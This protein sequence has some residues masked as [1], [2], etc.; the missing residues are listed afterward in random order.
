MIVLILLSLIYWSVT[1]IAVLIC[2]TKVKHLSDTILENESALPMVSIVIPVRDEVETFEAAFKTMLA[3]DYPKVEF[4]IIDDRSN[5]GSSELIDRIAKNDDRIRVGHIK[6]LPDTWLGKVHALKTGAELAKGDFILFTDADIHFS[7]KIL[8]KTISKCIDEKIDFITL[9]PKFENV[10]IILDS[11]ISF[12][13]RAIFSGN[14][15]WETN[16]TKSKHAVGFGPFML[17]R[18]TK[19]EH[20]RGFEW[21]KMDVC[22]DLAFGLL[23]KQA[24]ARCQV[25]VAPEDV[26]LTYARSIKDYKSSIE[27]TGF[28]YMGHF[29][30]LKAVFLPIL[31]IVLE[32]VPFIGLFFWHWPFFFIPSIIS[33]LIMFSALVLFHRWAKRPLLSCLLSLIG[34]IVNA[35]FI[36]RST[37]LAIR[38]KG[39]YWRG[40]FYSLADLRR[41]QR[42]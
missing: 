12:M 25:L 27:K 14:R 24:D 6:E 35:V 39:I 21:I 16:D 28:A 41:E 7:T 17:V 31:A 36:I 33:I 20:S 18:K 11:T 38:N 37:L 40:T 2:I 15:V 4:I 22:D 9:I 8:K 19:L 3:L 13:V 42:I 26:S 5:D 29:N 32:L 1:L 34:V 30:A 10:N 23:M